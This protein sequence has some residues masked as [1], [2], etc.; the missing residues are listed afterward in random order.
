MENAKWKMENSF[1]KSNFNKF[2]QVFSSRFGVWVLIIF[3]LASVSFAQI[4]TPPA[5][6]APPV[7][8]VPQINSGKLPNGLRVVSVQRKNVP[9]VTVSLLVK[10]GA[11]A[12]MD[13]RAGL[14]DTTAALLLKGTKTRTATEIAEQIEFLGGDINSGASWNSSNVTLNVTSDKID[15]A[16]AIMSDAVLNPV[17]AQKEIDL[18]K[19]QTL[20]ELNVQLKQPSSLAAFVA[21]RYSFGEH[22]PLGTPES[23]ARINRE[24]IANFYRKNFDP[25]NSV[26]I[27]AGDITQ[28]RALLIARKYFS[29]W[30]AASSVSDI[31]YATNI[32]TPTT[33]PIFK[34]LLVIDLP[35]SGQAAVSY[36]KKLDFGRLL[37]NQNYYPAIVANSIIGG[38]Y[39]ARLNEEI[40]IKRGLS[41][42]AA[43]GLTWRERNSNFLARAQTKNVSA[44]EV[45]ELMA[46]EINKLTSESV[47][48]DEL[49]PRK[50]V[51]TG[52]FGRTLETTNGLAAQIAELYTFDLNPNEL[53]SYMQNVRKVSDTQVKNFA[54][55]NIKGGDIIIVGDAKIFMDDLKKRFPAQ[56]IEV[57]PASQLDLNSET[58]RKA[59]AQQQGKTDK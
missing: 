4:E 55:A 44:A 3:A 39:S 14:A 59:A 32:Q 38:G 57:I 9:L 53:S 43:S 13:A 41:Y 8:N 16:L 19:S 15:S 10:S 40:R 45:A 49:S 52:N 22:S 50:A 2:F 6:S 5:P 11:N 7:L 54:A 12:E 23:L 31:D 1:S 18:Y 34:R 24:Q 47:L 51:L 17:F 33:E 56:K 26:L 36:A 46:T 37:R 48:Q 28:E 20:D 42:G 27:F 25:S 21:S 58:L 29:A 35:N 30:E